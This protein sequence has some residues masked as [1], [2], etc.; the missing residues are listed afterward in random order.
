MS[1]LREAAEQLVQAARTSGTLQEADDALRRF[2]PALRGADDLDAGLRVLGAALPELHPVMGAKIALACG[3]AVENGGDPAI[4]G[5]AVLRL[6][7]PVLDWATTFHRL[8]VERAEADGLFPEGK[9]G[10]DQEGPTPD[11]LADR[12]FAAINEENQEA[13]WGF[14]AEREVRL[15]AIAH[16]SRS[17]AVRAEARALPPLL[18]ASR[19]LDECFSGAHGFLTKMLLVLD[20][21]PLLVLHPGQSRGFLVTFG[22]IAD[23][24]TLN[25]CILHHLTGDGMILAP[26]LNRAEVAHAVSRPCGP[27]APVMTG[28]FNLWNWTAVRPDGSLPAPG[29]SGHWIWNEGVPADIAPF[30]GRRV[31]LLGPP[32]YERHW[33]AGLP[34]EGML[35]EFAVERA[36]S[37]EEVADW[38][39]RL[40]AAP[41]PSPESAES[42]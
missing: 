1:G 21:E 4:A 17:K 34:F 2:F 25:A 14:L 28:A 35:P 39:R 33:R 13:V 31:V 24:F 26:G 22:G 36:L 6:L 29:E 7:G 8:C 9:E 23:N 11:E 5:P 19:A 10:E 32:A 27:D 12:Y 18:R 42:P 40:A 41:R 16:L 15:S 20:D 37:A 3:A 38:L 30:E